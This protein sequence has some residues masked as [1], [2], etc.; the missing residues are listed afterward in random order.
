VCAALSSASL[1]ASLAP[2]SREP[3]VIARLGDALPFAAGL[4]DLNDLIDHRQ[5]CGGDTSIIFCG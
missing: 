4:H 3:G 2:G 5:A 1:D